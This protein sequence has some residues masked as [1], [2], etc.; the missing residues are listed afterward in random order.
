MACLSLARTASM[1]LRRAVGRNPLI[2][3]FE[4]KRSNNSTPAYFRS[5]G[6]SS[7]SRPVNS[8]RHEGRNQGIAPYGLGKN[9]TTSALMYVRNN[10]PPLVIHNY[11]AERPLRA[12]MFACEEALLLS[13]G[14]FD[15]VDFSAT[16]PG[17][18]ADRLAQAIGP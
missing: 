6:Q 9:R 4:M 10:G 5:T 18:F 16:S 11:W 17:A 15:E 3:P 8:A 12:G 1:D 13:N 2:A 7:S 14:T